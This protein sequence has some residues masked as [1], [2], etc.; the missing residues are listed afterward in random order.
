M[1]SITVHELGPPE[2]FTIE[3]TDAPLP[4]PNEVRL[5]SA[6]AG[7]SFV[8]VL[9]AAGRYQIKPPVPYV[10]GSEVAG[11]IDAVGANVSETRIGERVCTLTEGGAFAERI[12][13]PAAEAWHVP[14]DMPLENA[15]VFLASYSTSYYALVNRA[16]VKAGETVL[17]L[18]A[19]GAV[20]MAAVQIAKALGASVIASASTRDK[21]N[22]AL[23]SGADSAV[24]SHAPDWR[25]LVKQA[26]GGRPVDVVYDPVSGDA[27]EPAFRS[28]GWG[29]R[30]LVIGFASGTIAKLPVNL[31]LLKGAALV[32]VDYRQALS[33]DS[34]LKEHLAEALF[35]MWSTGALSPKIAQIFAFEDFAAAMKLAASGQSAGRVLLQFA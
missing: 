27:T 29:G 17:V 5:A 30:Y 19:G 1:R 31:P 4:G 35:A 21:R 14:D 13:V 26:N 16:Q 2:T 6:F 33:H 18:G 28:L 12:I 15:A 20:G 24:D 3:S 9:V 7:I 11:V 23:A 8:D 22:L 10:P 25:N 34:F 32:G